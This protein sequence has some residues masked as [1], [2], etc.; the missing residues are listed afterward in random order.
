[1]EQSTINIRRHEKEREHLQLRQRPRLHPRPIDNNARGSG[2]DSNDSS[3]THN[4]DELVSKL[5]KLADAYS[6]NSA[7]SYS[8]SDSINTRDGDGEEDEE[9]EK[10]VRHR[11][12]RNRDGRN[13]NRGRR[14]GRGREQEPLDPVA[15]LRALCRT[16]GGIVF[17]APP[18]HALAHSLLFPTAAFDWLILASVALSLSVFALTAAHIPRFYFLLLFIFWRTAY[19]LL[20]GLLLRLQ[21]DFNWLV[22][23]A[24][25]LGFGPNPGK[26]RGPWQTYIIEQIIKKL[27]IDDEEFNNLPVEFTTWILFRAFVDTVLVNDFLSHTLFAIAY[28]KSPVF[29]GSGP[30]L[31]GIGWR[32][33]L[34]Y[35]AG[36]ILLLINYGIKIEGNRSVSDFAWYWGDF[37]FFQIPE[38][39]SSEQSKFDFSPIPPPTSFE[40]A[41]HPMYSVGYI[42]F[43]ATALIAKSYTV[44]FVSLAAHITQIA[45]FF[46]VESWHFERTYG[47]PGGDGTFTEGAHKNAGL[48]YLFRRDLLVFKNFDAFRSTDMLTLLVWASAA[49]NA[50]LVG[51]VGKE[52]ER[53]WKVWFFVSQAL[54]WR[55]IHNGVLGLVLHMQS[56]YMF[57]SR[58][59]IKFGETSLEAFKHWKIPPEVWL[60]GSVML[61]HTIALVNSLTVSGT[62]GSGSLVTSVNSVHSNNYHHHHHAP[63]YTGLY[64]FLN[65]PNAW[66]AA[67][68]TWG[69]TVVAGSWHLLI[70]TIFSQICGWCFVFLVEAPHMRRRYG[71]LVREQDMVDDLVGGGVTSSGNNANLIGGGAVGNH[72]EVYVRTTLTGRGRGGGGVG[73]ARGIPR[74]R[75]GSNAGGNIDSVGLVSGYGARRVQSDGGIGAGGVIG[76]SVGGTFKSSDLRDPSAGR[77]SNGSGSFSGSVMSGSRFRQTE[78]GTASTWY[79]PEQEEVCD[80][81]NDVVDKEDEEYDM[82]IMMKLG[83]GAFNRLRDDSSKSGVGVSG[84]DG[85]DEDD[86]CFSVN[87]SLAGNGDGSSRGE[88]LMARS[89]SNPHRKSVSNVDRLS[90]SLDNYIP[91]PPPPASPS[92][93]YSGSSASKRMSSGSLKH[94][95]SF[96]AT[97]V[98]HAKPRVDKFVNGARNIVKTN[99]EKLA[100]SHW[101]HT[102]QLPRHLYTIT[103]PNIRNNNNL[104]PQNATPQYSFFSTSKAIPRFHLG[105]PIMVQFECV[106]E[107]LKRRD[108]IGIYPAAENLSTEVTTSKSYSRWLFLTNTVK[109]DDDDAT[110]PL[111]TKVPI[112]DEET[113]LALA[114]GESN[115]NVAADAEES[116]RRRNISLEQRLMFGNTIVTVRPSEEDQGLRIVTGELLFKRSRIPWQVGTY[117]ARYHHDGGYSV[118]AISS[119]FEI[120]AECFA[121]DEDITMGSGPFS[122]ACEEEISRIEAFLRVHVE[123]CVDIDGIE[124]HERLDLN[125]DILARVVMDEWIADLNQFKVYKEQVAKRIVYGIKQMF[126]IEFSWHVVG[127][128]GTVRLLARRIFEAKQALSP[129]PPVDSVLSDLL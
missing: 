61:K 41:P 36:C 121:W 84:S 128:M 114:T 42:G 57:W 71:D 10:E 108:W 27:E 88:I 118:V 16:R 33:W 101:S 117:E 112:T 9:E 90:A 26:R 31:F 106:R 129:S 12:L 115:A 13:R 99:V 65:H 104:Q 20:L 49:M 127:F 24:K 94:I 1:M 96:T 37:F 77:F 25:K 79:E 66:A 120:V 85:D 39:S 18:V 98:N 69:T 80:G 102:Q 43:Y 30:E 8:Y 34:R 103:F 51:P 3:D 4:N 97:V 122:E 17:A 14:G 56:K 86:D 6:A 87:S 59:F 124:G 78:S 95:K 74:R 93:Q 89:F 2:S 100:G 48:Q 47:S 92:P 28:F 81:G 15:L 19:N 91:P 32:D 11:E 50:F 116:T 52:H 111:M 75:G 68:S 21:S 105:A 29:D 45:F 53:N 109:N 40:L 54:F 46:F 62:P 44:F 63:T 110:I 64:R 76:S 55:F 70:V 125:E 119:P 7:H 126:G 67:A 72:K 107:T 82:G 22:R 123:R 60:V 38:Q 83:G 58:H 5:N 73:A 35:S 23:S 113:A